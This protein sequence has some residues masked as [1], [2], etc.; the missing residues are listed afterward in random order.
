MCKIRVVFTYF[1]TINYQAYLATPCHLYPL[2][3]VV[4][5]ILYI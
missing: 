5:L 4:K 2:F 3:Q 1:P